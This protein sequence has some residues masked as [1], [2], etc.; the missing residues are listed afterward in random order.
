[1]TSVG[2]SFERIKSPTTFAPSGA[3]TTI[4]IRGALKMRAMAAR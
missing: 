2:L 4:V 3:R 1:M